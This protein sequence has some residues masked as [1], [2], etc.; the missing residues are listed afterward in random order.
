[1]PDDSSIE[2][3][4]TEMCDASD[5]SVDLAAC[6]CHVTLVSSC[7]LTPCAVSVCVSLF[8]P[9]RGGLLICHTAPPAVVGLSFTVTSHKAV[10][11]SSS[12]EPHSA[13]LCKPLLSRRVCSASVLHGDTTHGRGTIGVVHRDTARVVDGDTASVVDGDTAGVVDAAEAPL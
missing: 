1:M 6:T 4:D 3:L 11:S 9:W 13:A 8:T 12:P 2:A 5:A 7:L 10:S